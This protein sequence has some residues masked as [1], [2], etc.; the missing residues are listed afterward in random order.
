MSAV[1]RQTLYAPSVSRRSTLDLTALQAQSHES[2]SIEDYYQQ[3]RERGMEY[4]SSFQ[5]I[6]QLWRHPEG[7]LGQIQLPEALLLEAQNYQL[8]PV[9]L[10][11]C[12]QV[13][14][15]AFP[16]RGQSD[17][18]LPVKLERLQVYRPPGSCLWTQ[19]QL[20]SVNGSRSKSLSAEVRLFDET[21]HLVARVE[22]LSLRRVSRTALRRVLQ[23][24]ERENLDNWLYEL[25]WQPKAR[26][27]NQKPSSR[28]KPGSW[29]LL[30]DRGEIGMKLAKLLVEQGDRPVLVSVGSGYH[31]EDEE[32]YQIN[33]AN[34]EDFERLLQEGFGKEQPSL[35]GV[36]HLWGLEETPGQNLSLEALQKAQVTG[37]GS[38]LH[39]VQALAQARKTDLPRLWLI[40]RATQAV[41]ETSVPLQVQHA[42]LWG[43]GRTL[44]LEHP[45]LHC[46]RLDL[47]PSDMGRE[48]QTLFEELWSPDVEDQIAYRQGIRHVARLVP[49]QETKLRNGRRTEPFQVKISDCGILENLTQEPMKRRSPGPG[50]VEIQVRAVGLNFRDVL[51]ALGMLKEYS[52]QLGIESTEDLLFGGECA[53]VIVAVG[54]NVSD[55]KVGQQVIAAMA[56][57]SLSSFITVKAELV[58][59]KPER[60]SFEEAATISTTFL[61][62]YY[63]L[64]YQA[65]LQPGE[66]VLI[67][68]AAGGVGQAAVQ[69]AQQ[70]G[71]QVLGS[72]SLGKWDFLKSKGVER[73]M[74]SRTLEF[75]EQVMALTGGQ[76]VDIVLNSLNGEFIPKS[77]EVLAEGGRFI[78][79]GKIGIWSES[80]VKEKRPD[81]SYLPFDLLEVVQ[82]D[83]SLIAQILRELM[84]Q[85]EQGNLQPLPHKV[86]PI[87]KVVDAFRYLASAKHI[88]K[89]VV[90]IPTLEHSKPQ[91]MRPDSSYLI[92]GGLGALGLQVAQWMVKQGA[93]HLVL[94][95][96]RGP[97]G[98]TVEAIS[99]LEQAGAKVLVAKVDVSQ[100]ED[101]IALI[102][103]IHAWGPPLR[104]IVHAA[105]V[106][107]DG[108]L[109]QLDWQCFRRVMEPKVAGA[110][111]LHAHTLELPLD[112]FVCFSSIASLLGSPGQGNYG[113][114]NAFLDALVHHRR[115]LGLPG[116]SINWGPWSAGMAASLESRD[117]ARLAAQGIKL[118]SPEQG[119]Q[120]LGELLTQDVTQVGVLSVNW[121][122][123]LGSFPQ[124]AVS[125]LLKSFMPIS[126]QL[127]TQQRPKFLQQLEAVPVNERPTLL[128]VHVR[129][130]LAKVLGLS[131][132]EQIEPR[133]RL[134]DLG[135]DSL[136]AVELKNWFQS[137]L[138]CSLSSTLLFDY[139]TLEALV[140]Y[141]SREVLLIE[142]SELSEAELPQDEELDAFLAEIDGVSDSDIKKQLAESR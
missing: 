108:A 56:I 87:A 27:S 43:L 13:L 142:P 97:G 132:P 34:R 80:Q 88:G 70:A 69:L 82:Q 19:A 125:P 126:G 133:Q 94:A 85:F 33:P 130:Q 62:A 138:G 127:E 45:E 50:E 117:R 61:T 14:G 109:L 90:S 136:M 16:E 115:A 17:A 129:T 100:P 35:R 83:P 18:Y 72:A 52:S 9:L 116:S 135:L 7:S 67:H 141:L 53:G 60:L 139:P 28:E 101:A 114:A 92:T 4:G 15:V 89:V 71:A 3:F 44:A 48:I 41:E 120:V 2:V 73:V 8:H 79:I 5:A 75:A 107:E 119:L 46:V 54:E 58:V 104:G 24:E 51:N 124:V 66:R 29:L 121:S 31:K 91:K 77:I 84:Q 36:V 113:A 63:G 106:L 55:L 105:G 122:E 76:G 1:R 65:N 78:E 81:V 123:F 110:W 68:A 47:E 40:T 140:D 42:P 98:A 21:G 39:L 137:S 10:D 112:F 103:K 12:F 6:Q 57:G 59:P 102:D 38:V 64:Y 93:R 96:R 134:F 25:V 11:A 74:N 20:Y 37:C 86:F 26:D 99:Q 128:M 22:G 49:R 95:S 30:N 32:R 118:I 111:N 131:D 23:K